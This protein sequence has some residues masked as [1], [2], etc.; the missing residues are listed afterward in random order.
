MTQG[1]AGTR[2]DQSTKPTNTAGTVSAQA[3]RF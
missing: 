1:L 3:R 2:A